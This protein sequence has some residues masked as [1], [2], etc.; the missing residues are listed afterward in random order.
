MDG[1]AANPLEATFLAGLAYNCMDGIAA[2]PQGYIPGMACLVGLADPTNVCVPDAEMRK[3]MTEMQR[4]PANPPSNLV[5]LLV[6]CSQPTTNMQTGTT[7]SKTNPKVNLEKRR[8]LRVNFV[9]RKS[10]GQEEE[11]QGWCLHLHS[12]NVSS[13]GG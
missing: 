9:A 2:N 5:K 6:S 13:I 1:I 8:E 3:R 12:H 4:D 10:E 7:Q 11:D